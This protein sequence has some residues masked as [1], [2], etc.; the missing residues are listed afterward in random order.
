MNLYEIKGLTKA[1]GNKV[2]LDISRLVL[3]EGIT[4]ALLGPNGSGKTTLLEILAFLS[5]PSGGQLRF[6]GK[7]L[8][9]SRHRLSELRKQVVLV[10]Q[11]PVL[12]STS[13]FKN[14][15]FGLKVRNVSKDKREAIVKQCLEMVGMDH[16][17]GA[18]AWKLSG[19]EKQRVAIARAL[20]CSPKVLLLDEPTASV[21]PEHQLI[22]ERIISEISNAQGISVILT[23]HDLDQATRVSQEIIYL[24]EGKAVSHSLENIFTT[25]I[26][27]SGSGEGSC[28]LNGSIRLIAETT[29]RGRAR[30]S[31]DPEKIFITFAP[32]RGQDAPRYKGRIVQISPAPASGEEARLR[33]TVDVGV[34]LNIIVPKSEAKRRGLL[35]GDLVGLEIPR[36]AV[37]V[38]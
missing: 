26:E 24:Y 27:D 12:F 5:P 18:D 30:I 36:D 15:E 9:L 20:A 25:V 10:H 14:V 29:H 37:R 16:L 7:P 19:G 8:D 31:L 22:I 38:F 11:Q 2:V 13:V 4:Y 21:D 6:R 33:I 32:Q 23:T 35:V 34:N 28:L 17:M 3:E 1:F